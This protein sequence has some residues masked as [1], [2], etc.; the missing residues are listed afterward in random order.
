MGKQGRK[1]RQRKSPGAAEVARR[2][3]QKAALAP[4][5]ADLLP[6]DLK[7]AATKAAQAKDEALHVDS[8]DWREVKI[9]G[10]EAEIVQAV[11]NGD[12]AGAKQI[13][14]EVRANAG[15]CDIC[16]AKPA[17][18]EGYVLS[19]TRGRAE[20]RWGHRTCLLETADRW[21][22][23]GQEPVWTQGA[24]IF[25]QPTDDSPKHVSA[26]GS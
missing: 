8:R 21:V 3:K 14:E 9:Q 7:E 18:G 16:S 2:A 23:T 24:S 20:R 10:R 1:K 12:T 5:P 6:P 13:L 19:T 4:Q 22:A 26:T 15:G 11:E 17:E 25:S